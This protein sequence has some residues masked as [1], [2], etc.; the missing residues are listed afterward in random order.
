MKAQITDFKLE[1]EK[2]VTKKNMRENKM[3]ILSKLAL[4]ITMIMST[5]IV[6]SAPGNYADALTKSILFFEG[7]RSGY[8]PASQRMTWRKNSALNDGSDIRVSFIK[9]FRWLFIL[10]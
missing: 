5:T 2:R 10:F 1:T 6:K 3:T 8:L 7:Q 9:F 4:L